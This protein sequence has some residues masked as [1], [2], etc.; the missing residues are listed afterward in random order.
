M[1]KSEGGG[2]VDAVLV[3]ALI[4]LLQILEEGCN[5][6]LIGLGAKS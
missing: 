3:R 1:G 2:G 4:S 6:Q 5:L